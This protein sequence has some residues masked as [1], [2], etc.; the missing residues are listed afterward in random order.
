MPS[1]SKVILQL[2]SSYPE[3]GIAIARPLYRTACFVPTYWTSPPPET[4]DTVMG[5]LARGK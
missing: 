5:K 1:A 3:R 2:P 4:A